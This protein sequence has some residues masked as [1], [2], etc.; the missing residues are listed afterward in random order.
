MS[1]HMCLNGRGKAGFFSDYNFESPLERC[2]ILFANLCDMRL[3]VLLA[4]CPLLFGT[5]VQAQFNVEPYLQDGEPQSMR[6]MWESAQAGAATLE[7]GTDEGLG[8]VLD[9]EGV[10]SI[11]GAMHDVLISDLT[12]DTPYYYRVS[13][14][15]ATTLTYRF[16][17]PPLPEAE[18]D[19]SFVAMSD[20][21]QSNN[22]PNVF[23][24]IVHQ[25][26]LD[27]FD[28]EASEEIALVLIPGDLVVNGNTYGQW[29]N[30]FFAPSHD[31]F[32]QVPLYPVLGNHEVNSTYYFQYF[33]LPEN[34]SAGYE[35]HW[36]YKDYGNVRFM[37]L[38]S[39]APYDGDNQLDWLSN[40]L[41][42]TCGL[43]HIDFVFAELH[44]PHKSELWTPGERDFTGDVV[45]ALEGFSETCGKPSIHFFGHTHGYSRGQSQDH[46]HLWINVASAGGAIDYW[47]EW[48]QFDYD[49]F[50]ITTDDWGFVAVDVVAGDAPQFTV[51]R[52]SRGD[53]YETLDN[54]C[55]DSLVV[56]KADQTPP[57][58]APVA[59]LGT[60]QP[61]ECI[62]LA[63]SPFGTG[64]SGAQHGASQWQVAGDINGFDTPLTNVW[65]RYRN[66]YFN[67]DTQAGESL[68]TE[69]IPGLP[70][71]AALFWRV[72]YR[73]RGLDWSPW[74]A[75]VPFFTSE[76]LQ[77]DNL[78]TNPGAEDGTEGWVISEGV[79]ESLT[80]GECDGVNPFEGERY[81]AVGGL[82]TESDLGRMHQDV[83]VTAWADSIDAGVQ[84]AYASAMMSDWSGADIPAIRMRFLDESA[85]V[86]GETAWFEMPQATW[87]ASN[88]EASLPALTRFVRFE[89]QG[90]RIA[91]Q[92]NDSYFD[93]LSLRL[94]S[95]TEC[96]GLPLAV[97]AQRQPP[98]PLHIYPNPGAADLEVTW[99]GC[100]LPLQDL[101]ITDN[102]GRKVTIQWGASTTGWRI[103]RGPLP[104]GQYHITAIDA[105]GHTARAT[106][107]IPE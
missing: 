28:G 1:D 39:N 104:A 36:W 35:E 33:H 47:G 57:P 89:M 99:T 14:G 62:V 54:V 83:D 6:V 7:W 4:L 96:D 61:P 92:D 21:Q 46:K 44:H 87:T 19:F 18:S 52:L 30:D 27:Y 82:C 48:P 100:A 59:P 64:P 106:W 13:S 68:T 29:S 8:N 25:G 55:T 70:E 16:K 31:L 41:D 77:G 20:M 93:N 81:F 38:N 32:S 22:D 65:E 60:T 11:G 17:T 12:P 67:E 45:T 10:V 50:E 9:S 74:T 101:R 97:A 84:A 26:V 72:R 90:T 103:D 3:K 51:K 94:G 85:A 53:N 76:S 75:P 66:V 43:D 78:L 42:A 71:N 88:I 105:T 79:A 34:G 91:G 95:A 80:A 24:E 40:V 69:A 102:T 56:T 15:A 58:P 107:L 5:V 73:D 23:D 37:G 49:E 63:A 98:A 86:L 2:F